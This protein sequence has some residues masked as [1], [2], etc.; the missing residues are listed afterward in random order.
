MD[1]MIT[2]DAAREISNKELIIYDGAKFYIAHHAVFKPTSKSTP[3]RIV[4]NSSARHLGYS[5]NEH[6]AKGPSLLNN[7]LG[8]LLRFRE[9]RH[10]FIGDISKMFHSIDI[11]IQDQMTHLYVWRGCN[12]EIEPKTY[13][14]TSVNMGDRPSATIA[15]I[16]LQ[17]TAKL[18]ENDYPDATPVIINNSYMDDIL[19][20]TN[21]ETESQRLM[22]DIE[23][24]LNQKGFRIKEW[25]CSGSEN[26][27]A[28]QCSTNQETVKSLL[29][30]DEVG[31][32][33]VL[34]VRWRPDSDTLFFL[35]KCPPAFSHTTKRAVLSVINKIYDPI[36]LLAPFTVKLKILMRKIW[37]HESKIGWDDP[38]PKSILDEW[39]RLLVEMVGIN[40]LTFQR[41][42]TPQIELQEPKLLVFTDGS[43]H[44]FGAVVY[45]H[46]RNGEQA[47]TNLIASK[48]RMA[49]IKVIDIVKLELCGALLGTRLRETIEIEMR[50]QFTEIKHIVD[51][52]IVHAMVKKQSYGFNTFAAN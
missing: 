6:L 43:Q 36:G 33:S 27:T 46:W 44:A 5:L 25:V 2:R 12:L 42:L 9:G 26:S 14:M 19:N 29:C 24:I 28:S 18:A 32:E 34:G 50:I 10:A 38:L 40:E 4:F 37:A 23:E 20:S 13:A 21:S 41:S 8:I 47:Y 15:Q 22:K 16:A 48:T 31:S 35:V 30:I 7:L 51:S 17:K 49:P 11:G 1:D 52:E 39:N 3:C 45:I